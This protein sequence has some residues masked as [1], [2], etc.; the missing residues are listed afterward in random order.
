MKAANE[1]LDF[2]SGALPAFLVAAL[3]GLPLH[4][5]AYWRRQGI[6]PASAASGKRGVPCWYNWRDYLRIL[7]AAALLENGLPSRKLRGALDQLDAECPT[8]FASSSTAP[9]KLPPEVDEHSFWD[10][11]KQRGPLGQL[12]KYADH[13]TMHPGIRG[14]RPIVRGTR[15]ETALIIDM[16]RSG[17]PLTDITADY[18]VTEAEVRRA[19]QF[20]QRLSAMGQADASSA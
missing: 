18:G 11:L 4:R 7:G 1:A 12:S 10:G 15:I 9:P 3:A 8:W 6:A 19:V 13:I 5:L 16:Y 14:G 17:I 20:E 2:E